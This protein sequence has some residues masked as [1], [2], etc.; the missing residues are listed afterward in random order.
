MNEQHA[1]IAAEVARRVIAWRHATGLTQKQLG[2]LM[3]ASQPHVSDLEHA[4][5]LPGLPTLSMLAR[6]TGMDFTVE[7]TPSGM[8]MRQIGPSLK[9]LLEREG[10]WNSGQG[11]STAHGLPQRTTGG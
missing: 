6:V 11:G 10:N 8:T 2:E 4:E 1:A 3:G 9:E 5:H 7:V